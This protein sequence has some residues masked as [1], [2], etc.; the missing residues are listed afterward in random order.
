MFFMHFCLDRLRRA[1][2]LVLGDRSRFW[3]LSFACGLFLSLVGI[4]SLG[5]ISFSFFL[6]CP[7]FPLFLPV[8]VVEA[9]YN[10][11]PRRHAALGCG[12]Q[13]HGRA[14]VDGV[15]GDRRGC[16]PMDRAVA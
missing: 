16:V 9:T 8:V 6:L 2:A 5:R 4:W 12:V 11:A 15:A 3:L 14:V 13:V 7:Y 1:F 10:R